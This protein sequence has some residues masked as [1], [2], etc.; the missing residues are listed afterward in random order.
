M[1]IKEIMRFQSDRELDKQQYDWTNEAVNIVEEML[2]AKGYNVPD[3]QRGFL[4]GIVDYIRARTATNPA[5]TW[6]RPTEHDIVDACADQIIFNIGSLMKL[7][8]DPEKVLAEVSKEI[9]SR[10]GCMHEGKYQKDKDQDP[11]TLYKADFTR[12]AI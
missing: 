8:Y 5:I 3:K 2:E 10:K 6:L 12:C 11:S 7:G 4:R 9:N 1:S